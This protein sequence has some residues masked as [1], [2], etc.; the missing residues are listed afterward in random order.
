MP[1]TASRAIAQELR[2]RHNPCHDNSRQTVNG[3][4]T[5]KGPAGQ[6]PVS[7]PG[8]F[9]KPSDWESAPEAR[10]YRHHLQRAWE[11]F[12]LC[13]VLCVEGK[14]TIY[15]K[16]VARADLQKE[17]EWQ[18]MLWNQGT[19]SM[20]VVQDPTRTRIYSALARPQRGPVQG[21]EDARLVTELGT[22]AFALDVF[23]FSVQTG[24]F[25]RE[26][27]GRFDPDVAIDKYLLDNLS[28]ARDEL[29]G[30]QF[31]DALNIAAAHAFLGRCLFTCYLLERGVIGKKQ[32]NAV[33]AP[34]ATKLH[35]VL[36]AIPN[37]RDAVTVLFKLFRLLDGDFNG[38][39][40]G[41][42]FTEEQSSLRSRH[43]DVLIRLLAGYDFVKK[44]SVL[45]FDFYDFRLVPIELISAIY[46]DFISAGEGETETPKNEGES[47]SVRRRAGAYYTPLR[48]A[49]LVVDIATENWDTLLDKRCLDPACGSGVFLV[50]L[51]QRMVAEWSLK[52]PS[53]DNVTRAIE[54][55]RLL[56][57]NLQG[58]DSDPTACMV[59]CFSLY[60]AFLDQLQPPD[61]WKLKEALEKLG[62]EK[63]LPPL[64]VDRSEAPS[65]CPVVLTKNFFGPEV[66]A[67]G[68]F[69]LVIG[70]PPWLGRNQSTGSDGKSPDTAMRDWLFDEKRN[71]YLPNTP[72]S[73]R[74]TR[75]FPEQQS[76]IAF[77]WKVPLHLATN[78]HACLLL[79]SRVILS[80]STDKFQAAWF[81][82]FTV[83]AVWQFADYRF[84]LFPEAKCPAI[85]L[86]Y[87][88]TKPDTRTADIPYFTPKVEHLDP[89]R[90]SIV[91]S[92]QEMKVLP[93]TDLLTAAAEDRAYM[94]WKMPFWGTDRDRRLLDRLRRMPPLSDVAGE[95]G[96]TDSQ[97]RKKRW[98]KGQGFKP[99]YQAKYD[100]NPE[101]YGEPKSRW[102]DDTALFLNARK[103]TWGLVLL[104]G[105]TG[106]C[107]KIGPEPKKLHRLPDKAFF[108]APM[109]L[110]NQGC[111]RFAYGDFDVLFQH[112][113]QS[114]AGPKEDEDLLLFLTALLNTPLT[115]YYTFHTAAN[116]G[117]ERDKV[118]FEELLQLPF[119]LPEQTKN[120]AESGKIIHEVARRLRRARDEMLAAGI[121]DVSRTAAREEAIREVTELVYRYYDLTRWERAL[122]EDTARIFRPSSTPTTYT[123]PIP[124]LAESGAED[125][126]A[127]AE[128]L[129]RTI[130]RWAQHSRY[131]L[132]PSILVAKP[133]GLGLLT[134][135][136]TPQRAL[137]PACPEH[138]DVSPQV[139]K[140]LVRIAR[141]SVKQGAGGLTYLRGYAHFEEDR[142]HI[143]KPLTRRHWTSTAALNDADELANYVADMEAVG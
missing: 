75:L 128:L 56:T 11:E 66:D 44:Q 20:L 76:A 119:P 49:E 113:I 112:A 3:S 101:R 8:Y 131:F 37:K 46:E 30:Q 64:L 54:L 85:V 139:R 116:L 40:F 118:H 114:I 78:G 102:W 7:F 103:K 10:P 127:Y 33:G 90:A 15:F 34:L 61:I 133:E 121:N 39:M 80:N 105:E 68:K 143:L 63:V 137:L 130:N 24:Q 36:R 38:S 60:L 122:V 12:D 71:P 26:H 25:Y 58:V 67:A 106:D 125:R 107:A 97:G 57:T 23:L 14:P 110:V 19:A 94:F 5:T 98:S 4:R 43:I 55:R 51:F 124:T 123:K 73:E 88:A 132:T 31:D 93:V 140:L 136:K 77:M 16:N 9:R 1:R 59:A 99:F 42:S 84:I 70:N 79:P 91:V 32:L 86:K 126:Q 45:D 100:A 120:P 96:E 50:I 27:P 129:C 72:K 104:G 74:E 53:A 115:N 52:N 95:T 83:E 28:G 48:L 141:A 111:S 108:T 47:K 87:K 17:A 135:S 62:D 6:R 21:S 29:V 2:H 109:V 142:V 35:H 134:I 81:S 138:Y 92:A 65:R 13:G 18:K 41:G 82:E 69:Q 117:V 22:A 89:R